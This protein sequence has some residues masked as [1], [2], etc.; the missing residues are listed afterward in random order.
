MSSKSETLKARAALAQEVEHKLGEALSHLQR[1]SVRR[2]M[3]WL[4]CGVGLAASR[5]LTPGSVPLCL[6]QSEEQENKDAIEEVEQAMFRMVDSK[7]EL[8]RQEIAAKLDACDAGIKANIASILGSGS[9]EVPAANACTC[10]WLA[11]P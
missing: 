9:L 2:V 5:R 7:I 11:Q 3:P 4:S 8:A 6:L 10:H 1:L